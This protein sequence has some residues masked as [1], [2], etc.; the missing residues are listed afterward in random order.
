VGDDYLLTVRISADEHI[1]DGFHVEDTIEYCKMAVREGGADAIHLS[2][3]SYEAMKYFLPDTDGQVVEESALIK[4]GL[5]EGL[6]RDIPVICPSVHNPD[7]AA[8]SVAAGKMDIISQGRALIADPEWANKV[9]EGRVKDIVKCTRCLKGC[10]GR[11]VVGL[12]SRCLVNPEMGQ[13]EFIEKYNT[14]PVLPL[15]KRVWRM[16][17]EV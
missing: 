17:S 5:K 14:R 16:P 4:K 15:K 3:G 9:R 13:E 6:G 7:L 2:D 8:E 11:F 1:P 12:P 10:I